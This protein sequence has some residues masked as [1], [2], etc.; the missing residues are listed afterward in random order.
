MKRERAYVENRRKEILDR[1]IK[2]PGVRVEELASMFDVSAIT[3]RR[4]LQYLEDRN[5]LTRYYGGASPTGEASRLNSQDEVQVYRDLIAR[6]AASL[7][8]DGD[9]LFINTSRNALSMVPYINC[10]NVTVITN[11]GRACN[12]EHPVGVNVFLTGGEVRHPKE[13]LVGEFAER[14]LLKVY[15]RKAFI[16]CSGISDECGVTTE[17]ANEVSLNE[18]MLSRATKAA[19]ILA[20]HT[21]IGHNSSFRTCKIERVTHLITDE[22]AP[23]EILDVFREKGIWVHQV[24]RELINQL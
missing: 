7:V 11:N 24:S 15:A 6:Y 20:D 12:C 23:R 3:I 17:N 16:G 22:K 13:A 14:N 19:Y 4:D 5:M 21:K 8:E 9:T 1:I 18:L 2:T 10:K